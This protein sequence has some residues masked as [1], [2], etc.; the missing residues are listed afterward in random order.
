LYQALLE[1]SETGGLQEAQVVMVFVESG[2]P[3]LDPGE[4]DRVEQGGKREQGREH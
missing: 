4:V 3:E 1:L 2:C